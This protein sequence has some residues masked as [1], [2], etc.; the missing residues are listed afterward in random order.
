MK[1]TNYLK[2]LMVVTPYF[3]PRIGGLENYAFNISKG[4]KKYGWK[5]V[6]VTSNHE[7]NKYKEEVIEGMK[8]YRLARQFK[9]SNTPI[10]FK[11]KNQIKDIIKKEKPSVINAHS[12]VPFIA[13]VTSRVANQLKIPS[14]L[15]YHND[16]VKDNFVFNFIA[17]AYYWFLGNKTLD[18]SNKIIATS[19][20]YVNMSPYL[21]KRKNKI[22]IVSPG[23]NIS[24]IKSKLIPNSVLFVGQLDKT[25]AHKGLNYLIEALSRIKGVKLIVVGK[26]DDIEHYKQ[27]AKEKGIDV[28]FIG[29]VSNEKLNELYSSTTMTILPSYNEAEGFGMVLIEA[30][31]CKKPVIGTK[32]GGIPYVIDDGVNGLLV[33]S[34]DPKAL[35]EAIIKILKNPKLAKTM[36]ENGYKKV[37]ENFTWDISIKKMNEIIRRF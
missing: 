30:M 7:E 18:L 29:P 21:R 2:T 8:I 32:V 14:V 26:G 23:V 31:A 17:K 36:G 22:E 1:S 13:D 10:S 25:H 3:Y 4:L 28:V 19:K 9:L 16:L 34:K 24:N 5:I 37:K 27:L 15:T 12:P 33:P 11:W 20:Y 6:V 35:A